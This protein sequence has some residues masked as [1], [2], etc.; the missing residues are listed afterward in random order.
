MTV[1]VDDETAVIV[2]SISLFEPVV[3]KEDPNGIVP[4]D[5]KRWSLADTEFGYTEHAEVYSDG[6]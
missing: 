1:D 4:F 3:M 2:V 5:G 6:K